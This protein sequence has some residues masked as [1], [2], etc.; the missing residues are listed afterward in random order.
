MSALPTPLFT[1]NIPQELKQLE[2]WVCWRYVTRDGKRTKLPVSA[3]TGAAASSTD[4]STWSSF[5]DATLALE[6][7]HHDG[8]GF[9]FTKAD[10]FFM[11]DLDDARDLD[12]TEKW[13]AEIVDR[14]PVY[15]EV[16]ASGKG[17]KGI[18]RGKL[19]NGGNR[20]GNIELYD[21]AR[22]TTITGNTLDYA[23]IGDDCTPILEA[24]HRELFPPQET[25]PI[26][27][28]GSPPEMSDEDLL[29]TALRAANGDKLRRLLEGDTTGYSSES[30]ADAAVAA[31]L[32]FYT[33][34][35]DQ[36]ER[37]MRLSGLQREKWDTNKTYLQ[38]TI[39]NAINLPGERY[40]GKGKVVDFRRHLNSDE[41]E[42]PLDAGEQ[43]LPTISAL[44]W[45]RLATHNDNAPANFLFGNAPTRIGRGENDEPIPQIIDVD[46]LRHEVSQ[47]T[48]WDKWNERAKQ[49]VPAMPP[50][51]VI[52]DMLAARSY[53]L[54][55]LHGIVQAPVIGPDGSVSLT[56]GYHD[57]SRLF[58]APAPGLTLPDIPDDPTPEQV[59]AAVAL[60]RDELLGDFPFTGDAERAHAMAMLLLPFLRPVI[61]GP[62]P[63]HLIEKPQAG[64]GAGLLIAVISTVA[65]GRGLPVMTEGE[66][67]D[68]WRKRITALLRT[69]PTYAVIDN[70]RKPL[71]SAAVSAV[72]TSE[73][74]QDRKLGQS[75]TITLPNRCAWVATGNNP[76]LSAEIS[77]RTIRIR[78]DAKRDRPWERT[79]FRHAHLALWAQEHRGELIAAC[80]TLGKAWIQAGRP[81]ATVPRTLGS[82]EHWTRVMGG[83]LHV[84]EI[85]GFLDN[86][87]EFYEASD[88]EG[89]S[90]REFLTAWWQQHGGRVTSVG[91][92]F[93]IA[94]E[95]GL[96]LGTGNERSQKIRLG[97]ELKQLKDRHYSLS[98]MT[99]RIASAGTKQGA[100]QWKLDAN[101]Q[102]AIAFD[103]AAEPKSSADDGDWA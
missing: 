49:R 28:D 63:L 3:K 37:L 18:G 65:A 59:A 8:I 20:K 98:E 33:Q 17:L 11:V 99:V 50:T 44:A 52:R 10:P 68:E 7:S 89:S 81:D 76:A 95:S 5:G 55:A 48:R 14:F 75:E 101:E 83:V 82:F 80:L 32:K 58:Y 54:P 67:E 2:Q 22:F 64:T 61:E 87:N 42:I 86:L 35:P 53:P 57:S 85:P 24:F 69:S 97:K 102:P 21:D 45:E 27:G 13:A 100:Q 74:W 62:T 19:P 92:L 15:W 41:P 88:S 25:P 103:G 91:D 94:T 34:D 40:E 66:D 79:E 60:I 12:V 51:A 39:R 84:A 26:Q 93:A 71:D 47:A 72:L 70:L 90:I 23:E 6:W 73:I 36:I 16:S 29:D 30:E 56:P 46:R 77:R 4:P 31:I 1:D 9:V 78:M 96:D 43:H 38:R